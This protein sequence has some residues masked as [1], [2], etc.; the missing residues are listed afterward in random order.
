MNFLAHLFLSG[1]SEDI[2]LGN[3][4]GDFVKGNRYERYPEGVKRGILLH[5]QIDSFTDHHVVFK[6]SCERVKPFYGR[7]AG[8]VMDVFYDHFL[9]NNWSQFAQEDLGAF[10]GRVNKMLLMNY[11]NMPFRLKQFLPFLVVNNR[12]LSYRYVDGIERA[13][14]IMSQRTS[15]PAFAPKA[16]ENLIE[17]YPAYEEEFNAFF[18]EIYSFAYDWLSS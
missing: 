4:I 13:L 18:T 6:R 10:V 16:I 3:F 17:F 14:T 9:A 11:F 12:L 7:Y 15:L 2:Q 1:Q 5:R 8:V